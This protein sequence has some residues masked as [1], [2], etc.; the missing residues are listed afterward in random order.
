MC[1]FFKQV[2]PG[3]LCYGLPLALTLSPESLTSPLLMEDNS[4]TLSA[5]KLECTVSWQAKEATGLQ[6]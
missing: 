2:P 4:G 6:S 1:Q 5:K 3:F